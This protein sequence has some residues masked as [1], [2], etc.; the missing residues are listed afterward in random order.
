MCGWG[1]VGAVPTEMW[2]SRPW[3]GFLG[4]LGDE[5]CPQTR[6]GVLPSIWEFGPP[7]FRAMP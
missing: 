5:L 2:G 1:G 7:E 4:V 3:E 6:S